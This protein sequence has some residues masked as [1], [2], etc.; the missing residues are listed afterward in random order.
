M[1]LLSR[2]RS[3]FFYAWV[4][5]VFIN[6]LMLIP[7]LYMMQVFDRVMSSRSVPTLIMLTVGATIA[8]VVN[9][10]LEFIRSRLLVAASVVMDRMLGPKIVESMFEH[11][12]DLLVPVPKTGLRD[13]QTVRNFLTASSIYA[14]FDAPW[15]IVYMWIVFWFSSLLGWAALVGTLSLIA[16]GLISERMTHKSVEIMQIKAFEAVRYVE[17]NLQNAEVI[18]ALGMAGAIRRRWDT[19]NMVALHWHVRNSHVAGAVSGLTRFSRQTLQTLML[20]IGVYLLIADQSTSPGVLLAATFIVSRAMMPV[21][22]LIMVWGPWVEA[23]EAW[24]RL[25]SLLADESSNLAQME[26][27]PPSGNITVENVYLALP[28]AKRPILGGI[29]LSFAAGDSIGIVGA[30]ASGKSSL[31]RVMIG[32]WQPTV[33]TVR[34]DGADLAEWPRESLGPHLGYLPQDVELFPGTVAENIARL[35]ELDTEKILAAAHKARVHEMILRLPHGYDTVLGP[36]GVGLSGGQRQRIGLARAL[37]GSPRLIVLD[38]PNANL[39]SE[40]EGFLLETFKE[41]KAEGATLLVIAHRPSL[42]QNFDKLLVMRNGMVE[43]FG[44][45]NDVMLRLSPPSQAV[46]AG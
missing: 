20:C 26:L 32:I 38:E 16:L 4:F 14:V 30:S 27:P 40:G 43:M 24:S 15:L 8:L 44:P 45:R 22:Q 46:A 13:L 10:L 17:S 25:K 35:G 21:E 23:R 33:G 11:A 37:Y 6:L 3:I 31:A 1:S 19:L 28:E 12:A 36:G 39:D 2:L 7:S 9:L 42:L 34:L 41:L 18:R 29:N 5:S